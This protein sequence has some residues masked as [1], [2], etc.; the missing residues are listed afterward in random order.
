LKGVF[1]PPTLQRIKQPESLRQSAI[2]REQFQFTQVNFGRRNTMHA[3]EV[4]VMRLPGWAAP[5]LFVVALGAIALAFV[6][7][8]GLILIALPVALIAAIVG[9]L[10]AKRMRDVP[11]KQRRHSGTDQIIDAEYTVVEDRRP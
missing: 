5:I 9:Q 6:V 4:R 2:T 11:A 1:R 3:Y 8:L 7:G 10:A